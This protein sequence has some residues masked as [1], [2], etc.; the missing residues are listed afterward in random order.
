MSATKQVLIDLKNTLA[1][2]WKMCPRCGEVLACGWWCNDCKV[3][4]GKAYKIDA[5]NRALSGDD[6]G[7][8][9]VIFGFVI[10]AL[11]LTPLILMAFGVI[12]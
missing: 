1:E 12:P 2:A 10:L 11:L 7:W 9:P 6:C 8:G 3:T 5:F 4:K